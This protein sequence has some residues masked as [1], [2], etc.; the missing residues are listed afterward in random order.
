MPTIAPTKATTTTLAPANDVDEKQRATSLARRIRALGDPLRLRAVRALAEHPED[1][2]NVTRLQKLLATKSQGTLSRH[3]QV[4]MSAG[5]LEVSEKKHLI[6]VPHYYRVRSD[7][8]ND[9][10]DTLRS[11]VG[12]SQA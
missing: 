12:V 5:F 4:L 7:A 1:T 8:I 11:F 2:V 10:L 3:L 9:T 6:G